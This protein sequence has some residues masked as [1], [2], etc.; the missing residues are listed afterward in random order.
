MVRS[1]KMSRFQY[2]IIIIINNNNNN[3]R[4]NYTELSRSWEADI[5]SNGQKTQG[6]KEI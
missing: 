2:N 6:N 5:G 3:Q 1:V 4:T